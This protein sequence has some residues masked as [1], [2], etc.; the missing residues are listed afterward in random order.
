MSTTA[1]IPSMQHLDANARA[2][3]V[4][5]IAADMQDTLRD[6][7]VGDQVVMPFHAHLVS[8][9]RAAPPLFTGSAFLP[10]IPHARVGTAARLGC[11]RPANR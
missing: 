2:A 9:T 6:V 3:I 10:L 1:A 4:R 11:R 8:A 5:E 7:T